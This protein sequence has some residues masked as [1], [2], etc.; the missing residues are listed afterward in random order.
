MLASF[1][2]VQIPISLVDEVCVSW[3]FRF[4]TSKLTNSRPCRFHQKTKRGAS[5]TLEHEQ[6]KKANAILETTPVQSLSEDA[7]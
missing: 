4:V 7:S 1:L 6:H 5:V 3:I 2:A